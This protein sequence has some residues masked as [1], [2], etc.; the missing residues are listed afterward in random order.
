MNSY[1]KYESME[2]IDESILIQ[3]QFKGQEY[4]LGVINNLNG[5]Y[6]NTIVKKKIA[7]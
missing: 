3:E 7:I 1:L 2:K 4:G 6:Q 5:E